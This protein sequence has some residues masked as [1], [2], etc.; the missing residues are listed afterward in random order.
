MKKIVRERKREVAREDLIQKQR[1]YQ[2]I[3]EDSERKIVEIRERND[4]LRERQGQRDGVRQN[5]SDGEIRL[6]VSITSKNKHYNNDK[7]T[8]IRSP[9]YSSF[10]NNYFHKINY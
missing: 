1:N 2:D 4:R 3:I 5:E 9:D 7:N 6:V 10:K 8:E